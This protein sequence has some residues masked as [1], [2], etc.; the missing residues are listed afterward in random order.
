MSRRFQGELIMLIYKVLSAVAAATFGAALVM[1]LPGF[2]PEVEAGTANP[3]A[4]SDRIDY[5]PVGSE[6]TQQAWPY[7]GANCLRDLTQATGQARTVRIVSADH[8][9]K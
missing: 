7:Y 9:S 6:C 5:R 4:K 3:I 2:S 1:A 8:L